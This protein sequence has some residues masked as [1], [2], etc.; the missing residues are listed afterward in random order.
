MLLRLRDEESRAPKSSTI[1]SISFG[2]LVGYTPTVMPP[3]DMIA[4]SA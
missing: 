3:K 2:E 1:Y 4:M